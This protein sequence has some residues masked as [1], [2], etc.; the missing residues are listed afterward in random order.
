VLAESLRSYRRAGFEGDVLVLSDGEFDTEVATMKDVHVVRNEIKLGNKRNWTRALQLASLGQPAGDW[1]MVCEDDI[2]WQ[3]GAAEALRHDLLWLQSNRNHLHMVGALSLFAPRRMTKTAEEMRANVKLSD[4]WHWENMQYGRKTWGAQCLLFS[5][6]MAERLLHDKHFKAYQENEV[7]DKNI[8]LI[9]GETLN[10]SGRKILYRIPC[11][12][13]HR[14]GYA[15]SSLGYKDD[16]PNLLT[17]YF[18]GPEA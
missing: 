13:D 3:A 10:R 8:D 18:R 17:D 14:L 1:R 6:E 9:V 2:V 12:V 11:L 15:N 7:V 5:E 4:G 16:R